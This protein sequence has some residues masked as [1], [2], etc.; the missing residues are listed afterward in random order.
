M[1]VVIKTLENQR[2]I[3]FT[4]TNTG[5]A[6]INHTEFT[7]TKN[8]PSILNLG[9]EFSSEHKIK[10]DVKINAFLF[11]KGVNVLNGIVYTKNEDIDQRNIIMYNYTDE[12]VIVPEKT[13]FI[14]FNFENVDFKE[15]RFEQIN[16]NECEIYFDN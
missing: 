2:P 3:P 4:K 1:K 9:W 5:I 11:A 6:L 7:L 13:P 10:V 16:D 12:D 8:S 15:L 14:S